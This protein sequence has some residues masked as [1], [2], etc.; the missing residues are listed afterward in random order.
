[1]PGLSVD[2]HLPFAHLLSFGNGDDILRHLGQRNFQ[3]RS[4]AAGVNLGTCPIGSL[5]RAASRPGRT[6]PQFPLKGCW[7]R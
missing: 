3:Q 1:M 2:K 7:L 6:W 5:G 4:Q